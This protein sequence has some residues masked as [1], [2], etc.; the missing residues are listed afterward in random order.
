MDKYNR[1]HYTTS[2]NEDPIEF[3]VLN[4]WDNDKDLNDQIEEDNSESDSDVKG[5]KNLRYEIY[6]FGATETGESIS[7]V[8]TSFKPFYYIRLPMGVERKF[9]RI[10]NFVEDHFFLKD[11]EEPLISSKCGVVLKKDA[12]GFKNNEQ[13]YYLKLIFTSKTAMD[14]SKYIFKKAVDIPGVVKNYKIKLYESNFDPFIRYAHIKDLKMAGWVRIENYKRSYHSRC[15]KSIQVDQK[16]VFPIEKHITA[17]FLQASW[18]IEVYSYNGAFPLADKRVKSMNGEYIYPNEI[19]QIATVFQWSDSKSPHLKH[20]LTLKRCGEITENE[21]KDCEIIVEEC[22]TEVELIKK[23][24]KLICLTDPDI[25]YTYNGDGFDCQYLID[26]AKL[27][28]LAN[29]SGEKWS[30]Y[31]FKQLS[32]LKDLPSVHKREFFSSSAYGDNE[33]NRLYIPGVLNYDLLIHYK[34]GFKKYDSYKLDNIAQSI[35]G[36]KKHDVTAKDIFKK[37]ESGTPEDIKVV[38][39]YCLQDSYLLQKLVDKQLILGSIIQLA[40]VTFVP[41][42]YLL[43]RGQTIKVYSQLLRKSSEMGFLVPDTNFNENKFQQLIKTSVSHN[44]SESDIGF[45]ATIDCG[46]KIVLEDVPKWKKTKIECKLVEIT[47]ETSIMV[48]CDLDLMKP[49]Y[50]EGMGRAK[51]GG[52]RIQIASIIPLPDES[53]DTSFTGATVLAPLTGIYND[54]I[55]VLDFASLYPTIIMGFNL[56]YSTFVDDPKYANCEGVEYLDLEWDDKVEYRIRETCEGVGK[57]GKSKGLVCGKQAYYHVLKDEKDSYFCRIHDP[58]KKTRPD[59]EKQSTK[60][61]HYNYRIV[62]VSKDPETG[63]DVNKGIL[64]SML[65]DLYKGRKAAKREMKRALQEGDKNRAHNFDMLQLAIKVSLN[66]SYGYLGRTAGNLIKKELAQLVTYCGRRMI[67]QSKE[68]MEGLF[69]EM[70]KSDGLLMHKIDL[71]S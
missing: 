60:D 21:L 29:K 58:E 62:Q 38:G 44:L 6:C 2:E 49:I 12:F 30:G 33:Y 63:L 54:D 46:D 61:V 3:Q 57:S 34:R 65:E 13:F 69:L 4:W 51:F 42:T 22:K 67:D 17:K 14:R 64:P 32:R 1:V 5:K 48:E 19:I 36:Q 28:N 43:T 23:W 56:D 11:F 53:K 41:L 47:S 39:E 52:T 7:C 70:I 68:Y 16:D 50:F 20:L 35:I 71:K 25:T 15:N 59:S 55:V 8:I 18:D 31:I 27:Y 37:Y 10:I 26:R 9:K 40:N 66:S 45:Y 24:I